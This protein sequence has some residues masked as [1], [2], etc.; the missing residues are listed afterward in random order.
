MQ[1]EKEKCIEGARNEKNC[2]RDNTVSG[3]DA[4][5]S[6]ERENIKWLCRGQYEKRVRVEGREK[7]ERRVE[8]LKEK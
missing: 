1:I 4:G 6:D 8:E 3:I 7:R 5:W 2:G